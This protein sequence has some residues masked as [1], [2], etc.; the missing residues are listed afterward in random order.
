MAGKHVAEMT[1]AEFN[2][3]QL[4]TMLEDPF[5]TQI[6]NHAHA[7]GWVSYHTHDSRRSERGFPDTVLMRVPEIL[8]WEFKR[9][10]GRLTDAQQMWLDGLSESGLEAACVRPLDNDELIA[11]L[12]RPRVRGRWVFVPD[13]PGVPE[14]S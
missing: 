3:L 4:R 13:N 12:E 5:R 14:A 11:R 10:T 2:A 1:T 9:Q 7:T 6:T 8:I